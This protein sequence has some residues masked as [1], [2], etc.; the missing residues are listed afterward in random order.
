MFSRQVYEIPGKFSAD[1]KHLLAVRISGGNQLP[2]NQPSIYERAWATGLDR[3]IPHA[4]HA[5]HFPDRYATLK[6]QMS[7]G[8]DFAPHLLTCGIWDD[9]SI[10]QTRGILIRN[11]WVQG[12]PDGRLNVQLNLIPRRRGP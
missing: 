10:V 8:W 6:C 1:G 9:V 2:R 3:I 12:V 5:S 11:I 4:E 7:F